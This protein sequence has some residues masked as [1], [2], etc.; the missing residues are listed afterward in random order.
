VKSSLIFLDG[1]IIALYALITYFSG[2]IKPNL[3]YN[4]WVHTDK[5]MLSLLFSSLIVESMSE[6]LSLQHSLDKLLKFPSHIDQK[7]TNCISR[8]NSNGCNK[9]LSPLLSFLEFSRDF[10]INWL[11]LV[12]LL[13]ISEM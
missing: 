1:S 8:M 9:D 13:K 5:M 10:V 2:V 12:F 4:S 11:S 7:L 6:V 3:K